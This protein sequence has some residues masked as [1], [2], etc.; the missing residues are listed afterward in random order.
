MIKERTIHQVWIGPHPAPEEWM[1]TWKDKHP[2][3]TFIRWDNE[4][5]KNYP[6]INKDKI[7]D[8]MNRG[9]YA[10]ASDVM[11]YEILYDFG[12]FIAPADSV[13][14]NPIDELMDIKEDCFTCY[15]NETKRK[16]LLSLHLA[17]SKGCRLMV[18]LIDF[19]KMR[20]KPIIDPWLS[21]GNK[22]LTQQTNRL[23]YPIKV[24]P[25]HYFVP[26][27]HTGEKYTGPDKIYA[28][29]MWYTT[30]QAWQLNT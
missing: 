24:Y 30:K 22:F 1:Q 9:L 13:C 17:S 19:L 11:G 4:R 3:W 10:G 5:V 27:H 28:E 7:E 21:T 29:H 2:G 25:S 15:E 20:T 12:G 16:K 23:Q 14:L 6:F 18:E 26:E 8:L